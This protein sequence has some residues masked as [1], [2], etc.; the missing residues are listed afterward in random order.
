MTIA[1][2]MAYG[3]PVL[4]AMK[5]GPGSS[6]RAARIAM[7][8]GLRPTRSERMPNPIAAIPPQVAPIISTLGTNE[9]ST[10]TVET[11][12]EAMKTW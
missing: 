3:D 9:E 8:T 6:T 11:R 4:S 2:V 5:V 7:Y 12:Y 1:T 10:P